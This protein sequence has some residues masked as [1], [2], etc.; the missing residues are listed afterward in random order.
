[1]FKHKIIIRS[2]ATTLDQIG[3]M[4]IIG[5][6]GIMKIIGI[7]GIMKIIGINWN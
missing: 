3:I 6:I 7:I 5:I 2:G 1:M 4:K